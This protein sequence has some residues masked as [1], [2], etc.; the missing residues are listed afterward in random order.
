VLRLFAELVEDG[1]TADE[2]VVLLLA[3]ALFAILVLLVDV[4]VWRRY[5]RRDARRQR[6]EAGAGEKP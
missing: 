6:R 3:L 4:M 5:R 2:P 1:D